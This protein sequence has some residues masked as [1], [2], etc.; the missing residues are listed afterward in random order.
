L[1]VITHEGVRVYIIVYVE[2]MIA[3]VSVVVFSGPRPIMHVRLQG[4]HTYVYVGISNSL[5]S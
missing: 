5:D 3:Y 4:R 1:I 2:Y